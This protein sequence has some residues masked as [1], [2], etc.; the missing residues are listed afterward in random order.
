VVALPE[1]G[2]TKLEVRGGGLVLGVALE[3]ADANPT[4]V[5]ALRDG[6]LEKFSAPLSL[7]TEATRVKVLDVVDFAMLE[8]EPV[9]AMLLPTELCGAFVAEATG[10][11]AMAHLQPVSKLSTES[12]GTGDRDSG[13]S[14]KLSHRVVR[15]IVIINL[16][17]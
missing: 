6:N 14:K 7:S 11:I 17:S 13:L 12:P 4:A 10:M 15:L 3:L 1:E 9:V 5:S 2:V 8:D 16:T